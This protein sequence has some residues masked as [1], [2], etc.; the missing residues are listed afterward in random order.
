MRGLFKYAFV[1]FC[2]LIFSVHLSHAENVMIGYV[3]FN[4]AL[5]EVGDG[6]KARQKLKNEFQEKQERLDKLQSGL[7][8]EKD[9]LDRD[10][11]LLSAETLA[12]REEQYRKKFNELQDSLVTFKRDI[13][14]KETELTNQILERLR[15]VVRDIGREN[16]YSVILEKSQD[17]VL[18]AP[19]A[20]DLTE[21]VIGKYDREGRG[22]VK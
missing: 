4:K 15:S 20:N 22:K 13:S 7:K 8:K 1:L 18:Y 21:R 3:D 2:V 6:K 16:G 12:S 17:I 10:R 11:L 5:N 14:T 9:D 19:D